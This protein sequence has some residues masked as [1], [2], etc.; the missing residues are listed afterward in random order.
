M[1]ILSRI[2][3]GSIRKTLAQMC[4][5]TDVIQ[6]AIAVKLSPS[7]KIKYGEDHGLTIAAAVINKLFAKVSPTHSKEDLQLAER[8]ATEILTT[9]SEVRYAALMSCR[10][11]L[12][13]EAERNTKEQ[14][15][16]WDHIQ[17]MASIC[18]LPHDPATPAIIRDLTSTLYKKYL[19]KTNG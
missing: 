12:L 15:L 19:K 17:W 5:H 18:D 9:D 2:F 4:S 16:L 13:F 11:R 3:K 14:W 6:M 7:Y 10:A 1:S 8:L